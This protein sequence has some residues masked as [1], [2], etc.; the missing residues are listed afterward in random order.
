MR[1]SIGKAVACIALLFGSVTPTLAIVG[2]T[3]D[4]GDPGIVALLGRR[5]GETSAFFCTG[6]LIAPTVLLT[7]AHCVHPAIAG[8]GLTYEAVFF[9][10]IRNSPPSSRKPVASVHW[11]PAFDPTNVAAGHNVAV[12]ILAA[13]VT[14]VAPVPWS[15]SATPAAG[16]SVRIVGYGLNDGFDQEGTSA[17]IKRQAN[18]PVNAVTATHLDVGAFGLTS[19]SGDSGGPALSPVNGFPTVVG[20]TSHGLQFCIGAS[21]YSRVDIDAAF[22]ATYAPPTLPPEPGVV[23]LTN[24]VP[25]TGL[26]GPT[27]G[28]VR[29]FRIDVPAGQNL[30]FALNGG[31]GDADMYVQLGSKPTLTSYLCRPYLNGNNETCTFDNAT[32]GSYYVMVRAYQPYSGARL[33]ATYMPVGTLPADPLLLNGTPV[34]NL[35]GVAGSTSYWRVTPGAG[36]TMT[37]RISGGTG[38]ADLYVAFGNRPTTAAYLC[39]PFLF[40][41]EETCTISATSAGDYYI[42]L[43][44]YSSYS[45][46]TLMGSY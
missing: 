14:D 43:R 27:A 4:A 1:T 24:G 26:S 23:V 36:R 20:V 35:S 17:G 28:F 38:D 29:Y 2:G 37:I 45:G 42:M 3:E 12:A 18:A 30:N 11:N 10:N 21:Q 22:I 13:P 46:V 9:P 5:P 8:S 44:A 25:V 33:T 32:P 39:R 34:P 7:A 15:A 16:S 31:S 40:G 6:T 41:N 19:C